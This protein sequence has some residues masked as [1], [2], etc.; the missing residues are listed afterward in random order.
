MKTLIMFSVLMMVFTSCAVFTPQETQEERRRLLAMQDA[1]REQHNP[2]R[3]KQAVKDLLV[4]K[5][6][7]ME[8]EV[9]EGN[10]YA[11]R[12]KP[13]PQQ[14]LD[15]LN[16][17]IEGLA[18]GVAGEQAAAPNA[19]EQTTPPNSNAATPG[20]DKQESEVNQQNPQEDTTRLPSI[21]VR[22]EKSNQRILGAKAALV[23]STR[24]N[25]ILEFSEDRSSYY[26]SGSNRGTS[27]TGQCYVTTKRYG[28][29]PLAFIRFNQ[30]T[31]PKLLEFLFGSEPVKQIAAKQKQKRARMIQNRKMGIQGARKAAA[32]QASYAIASMAGITVTDD[33]LSLVLYG[34]MELTPTG[35]MRTGGLR[36]TFKRIE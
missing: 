35:W 36:C 9:E 16:T 1:V 27:V 4:G 26:Y 34:D 14:V 33:T 5:W 20:K 2:E 30:R 7:Y 29:D 3:V 24:K 28:D 31:G 15:S 18:K 19:V 10:V 25:L 12:A 17:A 21:E 23:A 8:L 22:D 6:Q 32:R 13:V 11:Q